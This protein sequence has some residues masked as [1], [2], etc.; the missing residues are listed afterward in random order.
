MRKAIAA[1]AVAFLYSTALTSP[2]HAEPV[3]IAL[4]G[5]AFASTLAGAAVT[6][7]IN[8]GV[9][10]AL[11]GIAYLLSSKGG[12]RQAGADST[13]ISV[14]VPERSGLLERRMLYGEYTTSGG[15]FFQDTTIGAGA[16]KPN[17]YVQG[18]TISDGICDSIVSILVNGTVCE[19]DSDGLPLTYPWKD[20]SNTYLEVSFRSGLDDQA[21]D[22]II[23]ARFLAKTA[24]FRQRGV[25]TCV[26]EMNF[27][28]DAD[29]HTALWGVSGVPDI[30]FRVRG[31]KIYDPRNADHLVDDK[32]TWT[33]SNNATLVEAD[34]LRHDMGFSIPSAEID[35]DSI[36][37]SADV[38][39][40]WVE[41]IDGFDRR[42]TVN[43]V[44]FASE[45][46]DTVLNAM[47][48]SNRALIRRAFGL[49]GIRA[50]RV[51]DPVCTIHQGLLVG[52]FSYQNE[53]DTRSALNTVTLQFNP[54]VHDNQSGE[55]TYTDDALVL[56]DGQELETSVNLRFTDSPATAQRLAY[57]LIQENRYSNTFTGM[58]D[59]G[60]LCAAGKPNGQL[61]EAGDV[62]RLDFDNNYDALNGLY[63]VSG[64]E[65]SQDFNAVVS[66]TGYNPNSLAGWSIGLEQEYEVTP[67]ADPVDPVEGD[68]GQQVFTSSGAFVV[69]PGAYVAHIVAVG[70]GDE[71]GGSLRYRND[72]AVIPG[73][74]LDV[75]ISSSGGQSRVLRSGTV[76]VTAAGGAS[77]T[78]SS[79]GGDIGG[80]NGGAK[81]TKSSGTAP[82][83]GGGGGGGY[84]GNG[85]AGGNSNNVGNSGS[86]GGGGGGGG[87]DSGTGANAPGGG[88]GGVGLNGS[89]SSGGGGALSTR[90]G[91]GS[92]GTGGTATKNGGNYGGGFSNS[93]TRGAG[94]VR[95]MWGSGRSFPS[96][97]ADA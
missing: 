75:E 5:A 70:S 97:A 84:T 29:H 52:E 32:T 96:D 2:A 25:C 34:W 13:P 15:V 79:V 31:R 14:Q 44:V 90:G 66:L 86:G 55:I 23:D 20:G 47:A 42:G 17:I 36:A 1:L 46:N 3:T 60:V 64:L 94:A 69:P 59:I 41:T 50:D 38:D 51:S 22:P 19:I 93:G 77:G 6:A 72:I 54:E 30:K 40:E 58:F 21:I 53:T 24:E 48:L 76:L 33:W 10:L 95:I 56:A 49:Y 8:I 68:P 7:V 28:T 85:G 73:E 82:Y 87:G 78:S 26:I 9:S 81:G 18:Y 63:T 89:G 11:S 80:G 35:W 4:F 27:G 83:G 45:P 43:G 91:G 57:A 16:T 65:I 71:K 37:E 92:S 61:L 62:V 39:D 74:T 88:G 67:T 12:E